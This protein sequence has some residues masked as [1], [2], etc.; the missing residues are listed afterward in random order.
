LRR[1]LDWFAIGF[2]MATVAVF[3]PHTFH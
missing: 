1:D 2:G 3:V